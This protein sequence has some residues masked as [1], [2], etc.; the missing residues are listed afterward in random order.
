MPSVPDPIAPYDFLAALF[1]LDSVET[2]R[3][4]AAY[5]DLILLIAAR[6]MLAD[7]T[8]VDGALHCDADVVGYL[9]RRVG[10][11]GV[12]VPFN[13]V[14]AFPGGRLLEEVVATAVRFRLGWGHPICISG[15]IT[16][17]AREVPF[18]DL[19]FCEYFASSAVALSPLVCERTR[20]EGSGVLVRIKCAEHLWGMPWDDLHDGLRNAVIEDPSSRV[21]LDFIGMLPVAGLL[22]ISS[23]VLVAGADFS[24]PAVERSFVHQ[25][26]VVLRGL[27]PRQ[28]FDRDRLAAYVDFLL[29]E[30]SSYADQA[31]LTGRIG[32]AIKCLK[33]ALSLAVLIG[34]DAY[35]IFRPGVEHIFTMLLSPAVAEAT[36]LQRLDEIEALCHHLAPEV[37]KL[38]Q[39]ELEK[40]RESISPGATDAMVRLVVQGAVEAGLQIAEMVSRWMEAFGGKD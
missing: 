19:D 33:R 37:D 30:I 20:A 3:S 27:P 38:I 34:L 40:L 4:D 6:A 15:S 11:E 25:E 12:Y 26:A 24:A 18:S 16:F 22:P 28:V 8:D 36:R 1:D 17:G 5:G 21:K 23:V 35:E 2:D 32:P 9:T 14:R 10:A 13:L 39:P 31:K 29:S 7:G